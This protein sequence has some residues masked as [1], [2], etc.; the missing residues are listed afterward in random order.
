[1]SIFAHSVSHRW[2]RARERDA[3]E[4]NAVVLELQRVLG[5]PLLRQFLAEQQATDSRPRTKGLRELKGDAIDHDDGTR[6]GTESVSSSQGEAYEDVEEEG[7]EEDEY[8]DDEPSGEEGEEEFGEA[9]DLDHFQLPR[10]TEPLPFD[11]VADEEGNVW[12]GGRRRQESWEDEEFEEDEHAGLPDDGRGANAQDGEVVWQEVSRRRSKSAQRPSENGAQAAPPDSSSWA[13]GWP[14]ASTK[15]A[16]TRVAALVRSQDPSSLLRTF[17]EEISAEEQR[18]RVW[19]GHIPL[20]LTELNIKE[21]FGRI[22]TVKKVHLMESR[23]DNGLRAAF[24]TMSCSS[25]AQAVIVQLHDAKLDESGKPLVV[26]LAN[27]PKMNIAIPQPP[28][29]TTS[30]SLRLEAPMSGG[31]ANVDDAPRPAPWLSAPSAM[32]AWTNGHT[33]GNG[34]ATASPAMVPCAPPLPM[35]PVKLPVAASAAA[36]VASSEVSAVQQLEGELRSAVLPLE[37]GDNVEGADHSLTMAARLQR[38]ELEKGNPAGPAVPVVNLADDSHFPALGG[39][40]QRQS[41]AWGS[42]LSGAPPPPSAPLPDPMQPPWSA[43]HPTPGDVEQEGPATM[44]DTGSLAEGKAEPHEFKGA[45]AAG[46]KPTA[47]ASNGHL[48]ALPAAAQQQSAPATM[49]H[50]AS[51]S[52]KLAPPL[53]HVSSEGAAQPSEEHLSRV[54]VGHIPPDATEPG[55]REVFGQYGTVGKV[56]LMDSKHLKFGLRA[57]FITF[58]KPSDAQA[59]IAG[60]HEQK[61]SRSDLKV[62]LVR[63]SNPPQNLR[64]KSANPSPMLGASQEP[65]TDSMRRSFAGDD[66]SLPE[67]ASNASDVE[68]SNARGN[69]QSEALTEGDGSVPPRVSTSVQ[70][71]A[72]NEDADPSMWDQPKETAEAE[73]GMGDTPEA[74]AQSIAA[75][76][77]AASSKIAP[78]GLTIGCPPGLKMVDGVWVPQLEAEQTIH[79]APSSS[80]PSPGA[81][82]SLWSAQEGSGAERH[83]ETQGQTLQGSGAE[84]HAEAQG[85]TLQQQL[86]AAFVDGWNACLSELEKINGARATGLLEKLPLPPAPDR[87]SEA[88]EASAPTSKGQAPGTKKTAEESSLRKGQELLRMLQPQELASTDASAMATG[89][90]AAEQSQPMSADAYSEDLSCAMTD[91]DG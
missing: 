60:L 38:E 64:A 52:R 10:A 37:S 23:V 12:G 73:G 41:P 55:L 39:G 53:A 22:G 81:S 70:D 18:S 88:S 71:S 47:G 56:H 36:S 63:V 28:P 91:K 27:P 90:V 32:T 25:E 26:R 1:M 66:F 61:L 74:A 59:A 48:T 54:W 5:L 87:G 65:K 4:E 16:A 57:A 46:A 44:A 31:K 8:D 7:Y 49:Q 21:R 43:K 14:S 72:T 34:S 67:R 80:A 51:S 62:L 69:N 89:A 86:E 79:S 75:A 82:Q 33:S 85:Q 24:V 6:G 50:S 35:Q 42:S 77:L 19:V 13:P 78:P 20:K 58:S 30:G 84:R 3:Q 11:A 2:E 76:E 40:K 9:A 45:S 17:S 29:I 15:E 68:E 83:A